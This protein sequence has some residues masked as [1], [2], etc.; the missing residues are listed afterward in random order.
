MV[1][2]NGRGQGCDN[3]FVISAVADA[4]LQIAIFAV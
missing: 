1:L 2:N 4:A 3:D